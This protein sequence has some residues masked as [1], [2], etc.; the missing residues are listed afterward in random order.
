[1][2]LRV[3]FHILWRFLTELAQLLRIRDSPLQITILCQ[4][5]IEVG[6]YEISLSLFISRHIFLQFGKQLFV[7]LISPTNYIRQEMEK[8]PKLHARIRFYKHHLSGIFLCSIFFLCPLIQLHF[9][10]KL[11]QP[12]HI[13]QAY[14]IIILLIQIGLY[15][16]QN[17]IDVAVLWEIR[18]NL[19][20]IATRN[21][22]R[23]K[24]EPF[25]FSLAYDGDT[26]CYCSPHIINCLNQCTDCQGTAI[27]LIFPACKHYTEIDSYAIPN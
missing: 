15:Q 27:L 17:M 19:E 5:L 14:D 12:I 22:Q 11:K 7:T 16:L 8:K 20:R 18:C 21:P 10:W 25:C 26:L 13:K 4:K 24:I 3:C 23:I 1:M 2:Y 9:R 6:A